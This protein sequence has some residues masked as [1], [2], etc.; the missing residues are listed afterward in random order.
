[1][2]TRTILMLVAC[3]ALLA[4][5][6][7]CTSQNI[8]DTQFGIAAIEGQIASI[9]QQKAAILA[10][11]DALPPGTDKDKAIAFVEDLDVQA[12]TAQT[13]LE[14]LYARLQDGDDVVDVT[15]AIAQVAAPWLP[16]PY[17]AIA[18]LVAGLAAA[19]GGIKLKRKLTDS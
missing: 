4:P 12:D 13:V 10:D 15:I 7:S 8:A 11:L 6:P 17:N 3:V 2:K 9:R 5:L 1:M 14:T 19:F 16:P 18:G